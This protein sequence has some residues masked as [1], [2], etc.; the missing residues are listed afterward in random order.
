VLVG[1]TA[2]LKKAR[3]AQRISDMRQIQTAL[4]QYYYANNDT[5]PSS[6]SAWRSE[7]PL[8]GGYAS[9]QVIPGL[10]PQYMSLFPTNPTMNVGTNYA[11][12]IA[13]YIYY[14]N[15]TDYKLL[16]YNADEYTA[17]DYA[18][19][20]SWEDPQRDGGPNGCILD[21]TAYLTWAIYSPGGACF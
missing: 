7:C 10:V 1:V 3:G 9:S 11:N 13:C 2:A 15:G 6:G 12:S 14:S 21:G 5:Y 20:P 17:S 19:M 8:W 16:D 18:S 4:D